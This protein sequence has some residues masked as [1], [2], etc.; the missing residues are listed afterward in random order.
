MLSSPLRDRFGLLERMEF[1]TPEELTEVVSRASGLL[2][3]EIE[4][5]AAFQIARRSR[6]TPRI[7]NRM[8]KRVRDWAQVESDGRITSTVVGKCTY[9]P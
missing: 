2:E 8:L 5:D 7:A 6:G 4:P 9:K 3:T 1:Y